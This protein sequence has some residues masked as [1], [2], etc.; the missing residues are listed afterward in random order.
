[1]V[2]KSCVLY[3][4][5][6]CVYSEPLP[7]QCSF[8]ERHFRS[9]AA[10]NGH[11]RLH[12][13]YV[14]RVCLNFHCSYAVT[15]YPCSVKYHGVDVQID[16]LVCFNCCICTECGVAINILIKS[17]VQVC[18]AHLLRFWLFSLIF[19]IAFNVNTMF[20]NAINCH[21]NYVETRLCE[22]LCVYM[23]VA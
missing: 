2:L 21:A 9:L 20:N 19:F 8:C 11:M 18:Y 17:F 1:M 3:R 6:F 22:V 10:L 4:T 13:G 12:G 23:L 15:F 5:M 14:K 7:V 16:V